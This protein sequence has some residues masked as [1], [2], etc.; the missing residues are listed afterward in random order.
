M[1]RIEEISAVKRHTWLRL[2]AVLFAFTLVA[3]AC[4][5]DDDD[6]EESTDETSEDGGADEGEEGGEDEEGAEGEGDAAGVEGGELIWIH[7]QEPPDLHLDDPNN[8]LSI[9]SWIQQGM[10]ESLWGV[11]SDTTFFPELLAEEPEVTDN[12]DNTFTIDMVLR[13]GL[14]WSDGE[15]L[16]AEDVEFTFNVVMETDDSGEF[17]YLL[18]DRTG[19]DTITD[20]TVSSDTEFSVTW[21]GFYSGYKALWSRSTSVMPSHAFGEGAGAAEVN[22]ALREWQGPDGGL[23]SSGPLVFEE[24]NRGVSMTFSKNE[25]YHGSVSPDVTNDGPAHVDTV[26]LTFATDTDTEIQALKAGEAHILFSQPQTAFGEELASDENFTVA[27]LAG[28]VYE[29]WGFNLLNPHLAKPEVREAIAYAMDKEAVVTTLYAPLFGDLLP[30]AGLGNTYWM[31]NQPAYEDHQTEYAGANVDAARAALESAGYVD[32]GGVY[33]HP[34]DG[35]LSLRVGTTGGNALRELQQQLIQAQLAEAGI[36]IVIDNVP[37]G[38]Y[39]SERPFAEAAVEASTTQGASGDP[40]IWDI[41]QF[42]WVGGP[43]PG[44]NTAAYRSGSGNNPYAYANE[45]FD[46]LATECDATVDEEERATCYN[47]ADLMVTALTDDGQ[48]LVVIPLTQKPSFYTYNN[49]LLAGAAVSPDAN[50]AGPLVNVVDYQ[51]AE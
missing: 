36:D 14:T 24:W 37:G 13:D 38:A 16:T 23:P 34:E 29:H 5:D 1:S 32:E 12:G 18:G 45:A 51:L 17:V 6:A 26:T 40:T 11:A 25:S 44:G 19:W 46:T 41:T 22:E 3:A 21:E 49:T 15:P 30:T 10:W 8:N 48:G 9:T 33:T 47:E 20:F 31:S 35:E 42:A 7:E 43:W 4:G 2:L 28:P 27:S 50:D 39:F